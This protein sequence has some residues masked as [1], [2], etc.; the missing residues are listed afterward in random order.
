MVCF[1]ISAPF[2]WGTRGRSGYCSQGERLHSGRGPNGFTG[3]NRESRRREDRRAQ[4]L[5]RSRAQGN[6]GAKGSKSGRRVE[7]SEQG[8]R[9]ERRG[10]KPAR[11]L[12]GPQRR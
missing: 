5:S 8:A 7:R 11:W 1:S 12:V 4:E 10:E 2:R 3:R 9:I 6:G